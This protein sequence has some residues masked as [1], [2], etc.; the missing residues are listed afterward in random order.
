M[1]M[2]RTVEYDDMAHSTSIKEQIDS[3]FLTISDAIQF[4]QKLEADGYGDYCLMDTGESYETPY[5]YVVKGF[6][7]SIVEDKEGFEFGVWDRLDSSE[8]DEI[9]KHSYKCAWIGTSY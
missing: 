4:L 5:T 1:K 9:V 8:L 3:G 2:K 7:A 6:F